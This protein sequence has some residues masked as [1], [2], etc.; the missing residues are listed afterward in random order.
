MKLTCVILSF[1]ILFAGCYSS[2]LIDMKQTP[3]QRENKQSH[4]IQGAIEYVVTRNGDKYYFATPPTL[5]KEDSIGNVR[6]T[7][8]D[9]VIMKDGT[10]YTFDKLTGSG[11]TPTEDVKTNSTVID[12][13]ITNDANVYLFEGATAVRNDTIIGVLKAKAAPG[14]ADDPT[15]W[16]T[17]VK[18]TRMSISLFEVAQVSVSGSNV[19][20]VWILGIVVGLYFLVALVM[21]ASG[22][23]LGW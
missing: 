20:V 5:V 14:F 7:D 18:G 11:I 21:Y 3:A 23:H 22:V 4:R 16:I 2:A 6:S 15:A 9:Y 8:I 19:T 10:R 1:A 13:V 12:Y 17:T